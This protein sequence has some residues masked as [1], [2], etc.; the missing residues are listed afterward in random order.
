M[1]FDLKAILSALALLLS[2]GSGEACLASA[3]GVAIADG[4]V[5][6]KPAAEPFDAAFVRRTLEAVAASV[7]TDYFD[8]AVGSKVASALRE[9]CS[10]GRYDEVRDPKALAGMITGDIYTMAQD[11]HL[12]VMVRKEAPPQQSTSVAVPDSREM[13][14]KR[15]NYDFQTMEIMPGNIGYLRITGFYRPIEIRETLAAAMAFLSHADALIIDLRDHPGGSSPSVALFA[16]YV[17]DVPD[18]P[19]FEIAPRPPKPPARYSTEP[20]HLPNSEGSR[21][22]YLL[23]SSRT[24]SGGEAIA[25]LLQERRRAVVIGEVTGGGANQVPPP[26]LVNS[27]FEVNIPNGQARSSLTGKNWE[28]IG[29]IPDVPVS[30]THALPVAHA[31]AIRVLLRT[32]PTGPWHE[33]LERE[34]AVVEKQ[35]PFLPKGR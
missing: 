34:L 7:E 21:P 22:T 3:P 13:A 6:G 10:R 23:T 8:P 24:F 28:G 19:L 31:M 1:N 20:R 35:G 5:L 14:G 25:F 9:G 15:S 26:R 4:P 11:K 29:V 16:S 27:C 12:S 30:A 2:L 32:T 17:I 18:L 33:T